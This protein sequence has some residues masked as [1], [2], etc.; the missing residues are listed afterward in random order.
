MTTAARY[1][2]GDPPE[3]CDLTDQVPG[4]HAAMIVMFVDGCTR[5]GFWANLC[6]TCYVRYGIGL[7]LGKGQ[8]YVKEPDG[9]WLKKLG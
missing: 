5:F 2:V 7:G 4:P 6:L 3:S 8:L 1:W 9:R